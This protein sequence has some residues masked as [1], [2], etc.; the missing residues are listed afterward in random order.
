MNTKEKDI[1][2]EREK[3]RHKAFIMMIEIGVIIALPAFTAL[4]LGKYLD[5]NLQGSGNYTII[6]LIFAFV[7]S[8]AIIIRKYI[9]FDRAM[10]EVDKKIKQ[11]KNKTDVF[12]SD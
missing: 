10:K 8:W 5:N 1:Y 4:F 9:K 12:T 6:T 2:K 7:I 3:Y 11:E